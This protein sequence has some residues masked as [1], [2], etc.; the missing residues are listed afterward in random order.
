MRNADRNPI[1][2]ALKAL[3]WLVQT[4]PDEVGVREMASAL[5]VSPSSAHRLLSA[6]VEEGF[7]R[8]DERTARYSLGLE[9]L[10]LAHV[11]IARAPVRQ[12]ALPHMRRLVDACNE[13]ALLGLYDPARQEMIF[14]ASVDS[15]H[16]LRYAIELNRWIPVYAG[17]SGLAI[18][19]FLSDAE[20]R[21]IIERTRLV[22][23]TGRSITESYRL[24]AEL[25][26]IR[27]L[28]F[29]VT[30]GHRI[31]GAVGL[32]APIFGAAGE[33]VGDICL[34]IPEQRFDESSK[35][36]LIEL[37]RTCAAC[38]TV[39]ISGHPMQT[40]EAAA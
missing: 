38:V 30:H 13:T 27:R 39:D 7:V 11:A 12:A 20:I 5:R 9:F 34:T 10:R 6:L 8:Q 16:S 36:R 26:N 15:T 4:E 18:V 37:L 28:G 31:A 1:S 19:A 24:E 33:V 32:A 14:A 40:N 25:E 35:G 22:P 3:S 2:K 21:S 23:L 29:A 17:A